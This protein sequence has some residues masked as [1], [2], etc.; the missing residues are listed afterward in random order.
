[1]ILQAS[2]FAEKMLCVFVGYFS[3]DTWLVNL[4]CPSIWKRFIS[5]ITT[6][7]Y[8]ILDGAC[9]SPFGICQ[10]MWLD[11]I[12]DVSR[13]GQIFPSVGMCLFYYTI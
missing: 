12:N 1:M 7:N 10:G 13:H 2:N 9:N 3:L 5:V 11:F 6:L 8:I 4:I